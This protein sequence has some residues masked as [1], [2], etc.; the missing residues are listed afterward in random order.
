M[1]V[2]RGTS[3]REWASP[4]IRQSTEA[5]CSWTAHGEAVRL[6]PGD[7]TALA[8]EDAKGAI[9]PKRDRRT[10]SAEGTEGV[11]SVNGTED[12]GPMKPGNSVEEKTLEIRTQE[13]AN[14]TQQGTRRLRR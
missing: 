10:R 9:K 12:P 2:W 1:G 4:G 7:P 5:H 3:R 14:A 8:P 6:T 13:G 11:R